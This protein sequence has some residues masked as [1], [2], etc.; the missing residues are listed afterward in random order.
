V[1]PYFLCMMMVILK[2]LVMNWQDG[3][4]SF[5][6]SFHTTQKVLGD[7]NSKRWIGKG[8]QVIQLSTILLLNNA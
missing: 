3:I 2:C 1:I 7:L 6:N 4:Y 8:T 5:K